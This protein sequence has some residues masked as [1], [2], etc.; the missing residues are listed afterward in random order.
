M[1][2]QSLF[3]AENGVNFGAPQA[4]LQSLVDKI[5]FFSYIW[6]VGAPCGEMYWEK[7]S[8]HSRELF[9]ELCPGLGLPGANSCFDYFVD[10]KE[11]KFR[12]ECRLDCVIL[13]CSHFLLSLH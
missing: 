7:I 12:G 6:T 4:E 2:F 5:W 9:E 13:Y 1:L 8:E 3:T 10:I 11:Q